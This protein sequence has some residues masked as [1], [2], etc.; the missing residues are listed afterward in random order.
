M[1]TTQSQ[2]NDSAAPHPV[3]GIVTLACLLLVA[4]GTIYVVQGAATAG[5]P[6]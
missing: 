1:T 3:F 2:D 5:D 6:K 4:A